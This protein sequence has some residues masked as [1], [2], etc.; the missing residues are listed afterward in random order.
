MFLRTGAIIKL[1]PPRRAG[2]IALCLWCVL[3]TP[4]CPE[5]VAG[6]LRIY[7]SSAARSFLDDAGRYFGTIAEIEVKS[8]TG[9]STTMLRLMRLTRSGDIFIS[10]TE[11]DMAQ[12]ASLKVI[13]PATKTPLTPLALALY[14]PRGN[15]RGIAS[16][17]DLLSGP[18]RIAI[19]APET[20]GAGVWADRWTDHWFLPDETN[21][22]NERVLLRPSD[23]QGALNAVILGSVDAAVGWRN[24]G[25]NSPAVET[26]S[27]GPLEP[28]PFLSAAVSRYTHQRAM[29]RA[30]IEYLVSDEGRAI[31]LR[32]GYPPAPAGDP[33][34]TREGSIRRSPFSAVSSVPRETIPVSPRP[35]R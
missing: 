31:L 10:S 30:F 19:P 32:R 34:A 35:R 5:S 7:A 6:T 3:L 20:S 18:I 23:S 16:P 28:G 29:A 8:V 2:V 13:D 17:G 4:F 24:L 25:V 21:R 15:P 26:V 1:R 14:V 33:G 12:A 11:D 22:L 27:M 9:G